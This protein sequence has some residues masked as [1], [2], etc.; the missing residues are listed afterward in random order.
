MFNY[1][2]SWFENVGDTHIFKPGSSWISCLPVDIAEATLFL[3][4]KM[5]KNVWR[6]LHG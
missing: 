2:L 6:E 3:F 4:L 1:I 5:P